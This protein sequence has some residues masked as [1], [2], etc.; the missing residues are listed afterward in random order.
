MNLALLWYLPIVLSW[1][2]H[3][4]IRASISLPYDGHNDVG[5]IEVLESVM[6]VN[7]K[8]FTILDCYYS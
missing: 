5:I 2:F 6:S 8:V 4:P 7:V 3:F 1:V